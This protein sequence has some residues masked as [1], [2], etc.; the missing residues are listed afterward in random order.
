MQIREFTIEDLEAVVALSL[1]AWG[2][3]FPSITEAYTPEIDAVLTTPDWPT[4]Q[5]RAVEA[6][7]RDED[8][9]VWVAI[10]DDAVAGFTALKIPD[11]EVLGEIYMLAVDPGFQGHGV[12]NA[13]TEFALDEMKRRGVQV[14]MVETGGDPGH[15]PARR[16]YAG[17][18]MHH[19][20]VAR[21][22]KRL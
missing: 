1:R 6:V 4:E 11:D 16:T 14:A 9:R 2:P 3:V 20:E 17:A 21:Y 10:V 18:G 13:L 12:G 8:V 15:A 5:A 19:V 22:F 7:C